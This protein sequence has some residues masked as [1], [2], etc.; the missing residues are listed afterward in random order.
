MV[1]VQAGIVIIMMTG[2]GETLVR[3]AK[4]TKDNI[5]LTIKAQTLNKTIGHDHDNWNSST[6]NRTSLIVIYKV[7][8]LTTYTNRPCLTVPLIC[9]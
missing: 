6:H 2:Q 5:E 8:L 7:Q 4:P 3:H 1:I 9:S